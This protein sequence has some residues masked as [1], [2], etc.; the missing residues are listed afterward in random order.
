MKTVANFPDLASARLAQSLLAAEEIE[1]EI[2]DEFFSGIDWQ[3]GTAL[4]GI[5]LR[6]MPED[7]EAAR[8][9]LE[10][11]TPLAEVDEVPEAGSTT[12]CPRCSSAAIGPPR[13]K[14]RAKAL[15]MLVPLLLLFY[16]LIALAWKQACYSC[17]HQWNDG[18]GS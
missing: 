10:T 15:T 11:P 4:Q 2:P 9:L 5:R 12:G 14:R 1:S 16:P 13:W 8:A 6:V 18:A 3:M 7:E 17:G